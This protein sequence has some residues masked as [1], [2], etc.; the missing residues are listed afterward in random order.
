MSN[1]DNIIE[2]YLEFFHDNQIDLNSKF[3]IA[4]SG[5]LDSMTVLD[6]SKR[7]GLNISVAHI[8]YGLRGEENVHEKNVPGKALFFRNFAGQVLI[9]N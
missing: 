7:C 2:K 6:I 4:V 3:L 1:V 5:G 8:N 9:L